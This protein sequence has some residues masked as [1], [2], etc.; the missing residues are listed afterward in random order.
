MVLI[1]DLDD[2]LYDEMTYVRSGFRA[3]AA[4]GKKSFG[5]DEEE[6]YNYMTETLLTRGRGKIFDTWLHVHNLYSSSRVIQCINIY[7]NHTPSINLSNYAQNIIEHYRGL[8]PLY[9]VTDGHKIVQ[10]KKISSL[11]IESI[12]KRCFIT[13]RFGI[14]HA[15]P[16]LYCFEK[17]RNMEKCEWSKMV[18]V[19]DNP[20]KDFVNLNIMGSVTVRV[21]T[22]SYAS[23][24]ARH[25]FDAKYTIQ[26]LSCLPMMLENLF[27]NYS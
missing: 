22:G 21:K 24:K 1:F 9:L 26:N 5:L 10:Q 23:S 25:G 11:G 19:G 4:F 2:T 16:S 7:R 15:K 18:Y 13:H 27:G 8:N 14:C 20:A 6:S 3:V 12:F 17:I